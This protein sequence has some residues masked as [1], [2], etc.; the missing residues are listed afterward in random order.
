MS[1]QSSST[2]GTGEA[3]SNSDQNL[4]IPIYKFKY[5]LSL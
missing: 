2:L 5:N 1:A 4:K 3:A